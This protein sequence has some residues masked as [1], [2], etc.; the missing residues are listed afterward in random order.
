MM[1]IRETPMLDG[2]PIN[3]D[4]YQDAATTHDRAVIVAY[5]TEGMNPPFNA[6]IEGFCEEVAKAGY[7]MILPY[8][9]ESTGTTA[10]MVGVTAHLNKSEKWIDT[11][12]SAVDWV[13]GKIRGG[14][15]P[16]VGFSLGGNLV[17]NAALKKSVTAVVDYFAPVDRFGVISMPP[18][19]KLTEPRVQSLPPVLIHHGNL[20]FVVRDSQSKKLKG[21]LDG[22]NV[23]CEFHNDYD[24]GHPGQREGVEWTATAQAKSIQLTIQF[25]KTVF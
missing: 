13:S 24:C 16:F 18:A 8:Y 21:W 10:G 7:L 20:D 1:P 23:S 19:M 12:A 14:K 3:V 17:L 9:F 5:G 2:K 25:L 15:V 11:L 6:L 4:V 22:H